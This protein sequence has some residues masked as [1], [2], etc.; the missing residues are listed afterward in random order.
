MFVNTLAADRPRPAA[1]LDT[2]PHALEAAERPCSAGGGWDECEIGPAAEAR[3][4][5]RLGERF[6]SGDADAAQEAIE[7]YQ[8]RVARLA[9]RL[10]AWPDDVADVVQDVFVA[11][12]AARSRFRGDARLETWL[13][14]ITINT[15]RAHNRRRWLRSRLFATWGSRQAAGAS[16]DVPTGD[17]VRQT[18]APP[19]SKAMDEEHAKLVRQAVTG[20]PQKQREV[21][22]LYYLEEMTAA[23]VAESLGI[24]TNT[25]EVRLSRARRQLGTALARLNDEIS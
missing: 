15:C 1:V 23:E 10:L 24:R 5:R 25:V 14:R 19:D 20:L 18:S 11:A 4:E 12:L 3:D 9:R 13:V 6:A 22:V 16:D 8:P 21:V 2:P 17:A 7:R